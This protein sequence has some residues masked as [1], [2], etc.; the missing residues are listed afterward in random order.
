MNL[1]VPEGVRYPTGPPPPDR[2]RRT[3]GL[4]PY[5]R[6]DDVGGTRAHVDA[7]SPRH[8]PDP[9]PV[10]S[11]T[12][13]GLGRGVDPRASVHLRHMSWTPPGS[14]GTSSRTAGGLDRRVSLPGPGVPS[15]LQI[16]PS[17][18]PRRGA[19][20]AGPPTSRHLATCTGD[21][22]VLFHRPVSVTPPSYPTPGGDPGPPR[23]L[24]PYT[25]GRRILPLVPPSRG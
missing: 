20:P 8:P 3:T 2:P 15:S 25:N 9:P 22:R 23:D 16:P 7:H 10:S 4:T 11:L 24:A 17:P 21:R 5:P 18:R 6:S 13:L 1:S 19:T 14:G 12:G